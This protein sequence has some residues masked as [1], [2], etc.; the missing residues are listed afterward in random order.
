MTLYLYLAISACVFM[1][2]IVWIGFD[3]KPLDVFEAAVLALIAAMFWPT[4]VIACVAAA[5][6]WLPVKAL[7][8]LG[9]CLRR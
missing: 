4:V 1:C 8:M 5:L 7:L 9:K 2:S 3:D 6:V